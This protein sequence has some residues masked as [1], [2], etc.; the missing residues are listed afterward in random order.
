M[1]SEAST[2]HNYPEDEVKVNVIPIIPGSEEQVRIGW[3]LVTWGGGD[4]PEC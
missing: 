4:Q 2:A 3:S 1:T